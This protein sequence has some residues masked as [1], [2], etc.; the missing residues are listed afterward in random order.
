MKLQQHRLRRDKS[1]ILTSLP[2]NKTKYAQYNVVMNT[3]C[4]SPARKSLFGV[5]EQCELP[6]SLSLLL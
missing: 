4:I 6:L 1:N 3:L 2:Y 5:V